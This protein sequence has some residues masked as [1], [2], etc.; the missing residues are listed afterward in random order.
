VLALRNG[1]LTIIDARALDGII[2]FPSLHAAVAILIPYHLRWSKPL[3]WLGA[4][5]NVLMLVSA[6]PCGNHYLTDVLG[7]VLIAGLAIVTS[8]GVS[9]TGRRQARC[10]SAASRLPG[11]V[12]ARLWNDIL[13]RALHRKEGLAPHFAHHS[14][15]RDGGHFSR[16]RRRTQSDRSQAVAQGARHRAG[17]AGAIQG[18]GRCERR[19][20]RARLHMVEAWLHAHGHSGPIAVLD[21]DDDGYGD[22]PLFQPNSREGLTPEVADAVLSYFNGKR[23]KDLRRSVFV[24]MLQS[25]RTL[26]T[27]HRG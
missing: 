22:L 17:A 5:L 8:G 19:Y 23:H 6:I 11:M 12:R 3:L 18:I 15:N 26:L 25:L 9:V 7:G 16:H 21:D 13:S 10:R 2:S 1:S 20:G 24:R 4:G 14:I 27:G